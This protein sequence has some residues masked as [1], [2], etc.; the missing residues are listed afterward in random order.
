MEQPASDVLLERMMHRVLSLSG[1]LFDELDNRMGGMET[2]N[3]ER[4]KDLSLTFTNA[5]RSL[6][7][8]VKECRSLVKMTKQSH[9]NMSRE[10]K[11]RMFV[12]FVRQ[13]PRDEQEAFLRELSE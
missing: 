4:F 2:M 3:E 7:T 8:A 10:E 12:A 1:R 11:R 6:A 9:Q 5:M 13:L